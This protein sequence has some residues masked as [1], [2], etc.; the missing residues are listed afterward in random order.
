MSEVGGFLPFVVDCWRSALRPKRPNAIGFVLIRGSAEAKQGLAERLA[1]GDRLEG[2]RVVFQRI[3]GMD[4]DAQD[5]GF[6]PIHQ[7]GPC[8]RRCASGSREV[9]SPQ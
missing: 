7:S 2:F 4:M 3:F 9:N 8:S 6:R 1:L 5:A